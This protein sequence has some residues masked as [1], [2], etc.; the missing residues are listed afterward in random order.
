MTSTTADAK[1]ISKPA[2]AAPQIERSVL[3]EP[4]TFSPHNSPLSEKDLESNQGKNNGHGAAKKSAFQNLG[5]LD[6]LLPLWIILAIVIGIVIG[7]FANGAETTLQK[8]KFVDVSVP[9]GME[10]SLCRMPVQR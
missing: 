8:G 10:I 2:Q 9:V 7:N 5:W 1:S 4:N 3:G 6:R